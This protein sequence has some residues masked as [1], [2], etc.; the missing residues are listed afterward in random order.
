MRV[1]NFIN[2][3]VV[4]GFFIGLTIGLI[5]FDEPEL[6]LFL[7]IV[8]TICMYLISLTMAAIYTYIQDVKS[9]STLV[10][11]KYIEE[12]LDYFDGEFDNTE[13]QA[14]A[15][16]KFINSFEQSEE[17]ET[18]GQVAQNMSDIGLISA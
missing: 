3:S 2:L 7:L 16:A 11:K 9:S 1:S 14:R 6:V 8:V 15:F 17:Q 13:K 5:T 4:S 12:Q 18:I 10:N